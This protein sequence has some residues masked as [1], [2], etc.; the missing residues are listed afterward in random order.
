MAPQPTQSE[1]IAS[2]QQA[3]T[4]I[5]TLKLEVDGY[6]EPIA[7][8]GMGCR[9]PGDVNTP[10][11]YWNMLREGISALD[12]A[13]EGRWQRSS[14]GRPHAD[15]QPS[16]EPNGF[17]GHYVQD[18]GLFDAHFFGISPRE[19][20]WMD[21]QQQLLLEVSI[22]ALEHANLPVDSLL[23]SRTGAYIGL[24]N[25][26]Y[27]SSQ[28]DAD[29]LD[30]YAGTGGGISFPAGRLSYS[31]GLRGPTMT[32][33]TACSS[34]LV[35]THLACQA[36]RVKECDLAL[37]G[38]V[39]LIL[40]P[41]S[42]EMLV[43]M[44]ATS[45]DGRSKTFDAAADGYGRGEGCGVLVLKRLSDAQ[46]DGDRIWALIRGSAVN[47]D[48]RSG[49]LTVP[50]GPAQ[51]E[52]LQQALAVAQVN[53]HEISYIEAHGTGTSLGDPIEV[54]SLGNV[55]CKNRQ[56]P[57]FIGSA[58][59]NIGHLEP[60]AGVAGLIKVILS[61]Q[62]KRLPPHLH[63]QQPNPHI[64]WEQ[65]P[66]QVPT[67]VTEWRS[68]KPLLAGVSSFGL[69]GINAHTILEEAPVT[70]AEP[71]IERQAWRL[72]TLSAKSRQALLDLAQRYH[73]EGLRNPAVKFGD[74]CY[75]THV[76]RTHYPYRLGVVAS[77][78]EDAQT[79]LISY[80]KQESVQGVVENKAPE[81]P[82]K[83]AFLF[84]GQGS[85][86]PG[87]GQ[88]LY[89]TE[90]IFRNVLERCDAVF[91]EVMGRSLIEL[92]Y[93]ESEPRHNDLME[94]H[95]C[96]QAA[97]FAIECALAD[98]W[99]SWGVLP[100]VV[101]GHSLGDF[102]AA[103]TAGVLSLEDG[104]R[105]V[106]ERG[107]LMETAL[108]SMVSVLASEEDVMPFV[109]P[110]DDVTIGVVN[111]PN[112][113]V[114]SGS[115]ENSALV[116]TEL[117]AAGF[118]T[119]TLDIPV[120]AHSPMLEPV[121]DDFEASVRQVKLSAPQIPV[122]SSMTGELVSDELVNPI[123]WR[124]HL[125]NTVR[126]GDGVQTL[127]EQGVGILV[128]IGPK[129]TLLGMAG[130][131][132]SGKDTP[133]T[134]QPTTCYLPSL[135]EGQSDGQ[136]MLESLGALYTQGVEIDWEELDKENQRCKVVLPTYPFQ[137]RR[138]W[139]QASMHESTISGSLTPIL[140]M[141]RDGD[142]SQLQQQLL[143]TGKLT[144][145][146]QAAL[147]A[148]LQVLIDQQQQQATDGNVVSDYYNAVSKMYLTGEDQ[149]YSAEGFLTFGILPE[150]VPDF[151]W[152]LSLGE[153]TRRKEVSD[154][155]RR[156]QE[157]LRTLLFSTVDFA[158]CRTVMDFGCGYG[159]DLIA[160]AEQ[161]P[162]LV[163]CG[164]TISNE[165][166]A[167][168]QQKVA[169][170]GLAERIDIFCR[171][172]VTEPF[173]QSNDLVMGIE[174]ACH[175]QNK[176]EL[177]ANIRDHLN[178]GGMVVLADFI[179]H[180]GFSVEHEETSSYLATSEEW[181]AALGHAG[182]KLVHHIDTSREIANFLD[183]PDF[184][185]H[186]SQLMSDNEFEENVYAMI[187]ANNNQQKLMREGLLSYALLAAQ[188]QDDLSGEAL[189]DWNRTILES[190]STYA[191]ITPSQWLYDVQ[192]QPASLPEPVEMIQ[193]AGSWLIFA[194]DQGIGEALD[195]HLAD[196]G[197]QTILVWPGEG[198]EALDRGWRINPVSSS[199]LQQVLRDA[200]PQGQPLRGIIHLWSTQAN[201]EEAVSLTQIE[202][203]QVLGCGSTLSLISTL[204]QLEETP[205]LW[206]VTQEA[207]AV[208]GTTP[209]ITQAP[210]WG[211]GGTIAQE[212]PTLQCIR[213]DLDKSTA[214]VNA[215][216]L[217]SELLVSDK[218]ERIAYRDD[219]RY[220]A[221]LG[222]FVVQE[223]PQTQVVIDAG[224]SYLVTGGTGGLGL[225]VARWLVE[226]GARHLVLTSR[227]GATSAAA[228][229]TI[230]QL[231]TVGA[232]IQVLQS[233]VTNAD[234]VE[235]LLQIIEHNLPPL[236]GI[237]HT[238]GVAERTYLQDQ[239]WDTFQQIM[240][241]KVQG[242]WHL[243]MMTQRLP[244]DFVVY[245][246]SASSVLDT[247]GMGSYAAANAFLDGMA[248]YRQAAGLPTLSINW[249]LWAEVGMAVTSQQ[250][251]LAHASERDSFIS[252]IEPAQ[253]LEQ[254]EVLLSQDAVQVGVY[255]I[256]WLRYRE[257]SPAYATSH[258]FARFM[259]ETPT[260]VLP[261]LHGAQTTLE[262]FS[263][264]ERLEK[265][266]DLLQH[267]IT[268]VMRLDATEL[269]LQQPLIEIG[270]DSL[271]AV[272]LRNQIQ[273]A[274]NID[275][276]ITH[277][278]DGSSTQRLVSYVDDQ[279]QKTLMNSSGAPSVSDDVH[280]GSI[281]STPDHTKMTEG[282]I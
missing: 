179:S 186:L 72:L 20:E 49:G 238:A 111:G 260:H 272:Q 4:V 250:K 157:E 124:K 227:R 125:R 54:R 2:L 98:L 279:Y 65:Y 213:L 56:H 39:S 106:T 53:A 220:A 79:N 277:F 75:T 156:G 32:V 236:R 206:L 26:D 14:N 176:S 158:T 160:L 232:Q 130:E 133:T 259:P 16:V 256:N 121:L 131:I 102:A 27:M 86:Y 219:N 113:V 37:S 46:R 153:K 100:G 249:G 199:D 90:P 167:V 235:E 137:R 182:L 17:W 135:R 202:K 21:P 15:G 61:L 178:P 212:F 9:F 245:F 1:L 181:L 240:A 270:L 196:S 69:S 208:N 128:E 6:H 64:P 169:S 73:D 244:L 211:L 67:S 36:L 175:I 141:I 262:S 183:E 216:R 218:T 70:K 154:L 159:T 180:A 251:S 84:T 116:I 127:S 10:A 66:I 62:N 80:L 19:A 247:G 229:A 119:R 68:E 190:P 115:Y 123:Y 63:F 30:V 22:E 126:F 101:L 144:T 234:D 200:L 92:F 281:T 263:P 44:Q 107:Q 91:Q 192:W 276:P 103:Y 242:S 136:Q 221:Q 168:G 172:S 163:L 25:L 195:Q 165:Q 278:I 97:N 139:S 140:Q 217:L 81:Y 268:A 59:T 118:K 171:N 198:F 166:A 222:R 150:V 267:R 147:P 146:M 34:S 5:E 252:L 170:R 52:L 13:P 12:R 96:A 77:S 87:M 228:Q 269:D 114:V 145:D 41:T 203:A 194:D 205:R 31:L 29:K 155:V 99:R 76:G 48:G 134:P 7:V 264:K 230:Q 258:F 78:A 43:K 120:A 275:V 74:I 3:A 45:P 271:M 231:K 215:K 225:L 35:T 164:Y 142:F 149:I 162:H 197:Q 18:V 152:I 255:P 110:F 109:L 51:E 204:A 108:G 280:T 282:V 104:L 174:V 38:G 57:L 143:T 187:V 237:L 58:K 226:Q 261:K 184:D 214:Q 42:N 151:S 209:A 83:V 233:D 8:I 274:L 40:S 265:L 105:L 55:L 33:G 177:F 60:A 161:H 223:Q 94:S 88:E 273:R 210:L 11:E 191:E 112:S 253:G 193:N 50:S 241:P 95:A 254:L 93:P 248:H 257:L 224:S 89:A 246:S 85:Q 117:K 129:P 138:Y 71:V 28:Q 122:I 47:H 189:D 201:D 132:I 185:E 24:M 82:P 266:S 239:S 243:H 173:P 207:V 23:G 188:Q 148:V